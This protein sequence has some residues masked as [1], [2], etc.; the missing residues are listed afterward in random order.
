MNSLSD[1]PKSESEYWE[2]AEVEL[3][4]M[5]EPTKCE[6]YFLQDGSRGIKCHRCGIGF[7]VGVGDVL[8][9]GHLYHSN[10]LIV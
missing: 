9:D 8:K 3:R 4:N 6:H 2:N 1:L 7:F 10:K 5:A